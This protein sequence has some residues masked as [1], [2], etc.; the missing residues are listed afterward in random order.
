MSINFP[1]EQVALIDSMK[2]YI[3]QLQT[4]VERLWKRAG[5]VPEWSP[6][7]PS[8]QLPDLMGSPTDPGGGGGN[9]SQIKFGRTLSPATKN[10]S[11]VVAILSYNGTAW[12]PNGTTE[13]CDLLFFDIG[14]N[15]NCAIARNG[16][17]SQ[18]VVISREC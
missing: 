18:Y 14:A 13:T 8:T 6:G 17:S 10:N 16:A 7:I 11:V 5:P 9:N 15:K 12:A 4:D 2:Q 1:E 3:N